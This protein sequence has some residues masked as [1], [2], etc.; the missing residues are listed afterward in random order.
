M[1]NVYISLTPGQGVCVSVCASLRGVATTLFNGI[2][3]C[4]LRVDVVG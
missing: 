3:L 2:H 1:P 4:V